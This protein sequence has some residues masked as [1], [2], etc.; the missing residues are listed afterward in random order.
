MYLTATV[1]DVTVSQASVY[2]LLGYG[3][4]FFGLILL[5]LVVVLLGKCF[6]SA[7][8]RYQ[9][10]E[11]PEAK[12]VEPAVPV[13]A[14]GSAGQVKLHNVAPKTAAMLMAITAY[15]MGKPINELRFISIREVSQ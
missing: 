12:P 14:P 8:N 2:A 3:I 11:T 13:A 5:M 6:V 10:A 1:S 15:Q 4:V 7:A 9:K